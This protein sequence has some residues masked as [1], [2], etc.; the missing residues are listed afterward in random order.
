MSQRVGSRSGSPATESAEQQALE[1]REAVSGCRK[2]DER[3]DVRLAHA[4][5]ARR[6]G[7]A[8]PQD[9]LDLGLDAIARG[10]QE[11]RAHGAIEAAE[12]H[13]HDLLV[14]LAGQLAEGEAN[15]TFRRHA[16]AAHLVPERTP[17]HGAQERI[18]HPRERAALQRGDAG[19]VEQQQEIAVVA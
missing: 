2:T 15:G 1:A 6:V 18:V 12:D 19:G 8:S 4:V 13:G 17:E 14:G 5:G 3:V 10:R 11:V 7:R 16:V 9:A